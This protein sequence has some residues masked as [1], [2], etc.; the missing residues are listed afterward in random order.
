MNTTENRNKNSNNNK[1]QIYGL[2]HESDLLIKEYFYLNLYGVIC[3][4]QAIMAYDIV[5][6]KRE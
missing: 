2:K 1:N 3:G 6:V 5:E 4:P